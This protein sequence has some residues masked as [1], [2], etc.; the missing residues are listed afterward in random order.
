[1]LKRKL[2]LIL[3]LAALDKMQTTLQSQNEAASAELKRQ[4]D[5]VKDGVALNV[6]ACICIRAILVWQNR[7]FNPRVTC[8]R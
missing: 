4:V 8:L 2:T 6:P 5:L 7:M 3:N 1:M